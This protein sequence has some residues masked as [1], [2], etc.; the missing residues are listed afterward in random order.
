MA[1]INFDSENVGY[2]TI[3]PDSKYFTVS[4]GPYLF[5]RSSIEITD[6][7]PD[8]IYK[9]IVDAYKNGW[10]R[11]LAHVTERDYFHIVLSNE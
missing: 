9:I 7:C 6:A 5:N 3:S 8:A 1:K 10:I 11:P 2:K 4:N